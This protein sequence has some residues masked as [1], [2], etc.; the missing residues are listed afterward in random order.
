MA[1]QMTKIIESAAQATRIGFSRALRN[2]GTTQVRDGF[3]VIVYMDCT[4]LEWPLRA[5]PRASTSATGAGSI[6]RCPLGAPR[7]LVFTYYAPAGLGFRV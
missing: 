6:A 4:E 7:V 5:M 1:L 2:P 3:R